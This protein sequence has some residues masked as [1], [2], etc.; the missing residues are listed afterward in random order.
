MDVE[1]TKKNLRVQNKGMDPKFAGSPIKW[2]TNMK[3][4]ALEPVKFI[5]Y[6]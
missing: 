3:V 4:K 2:P 6:D 5:D 1:K